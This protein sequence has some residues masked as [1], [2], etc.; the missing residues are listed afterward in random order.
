MSTQEVFFSKK[1]SQL[2]LCVLN[3]TCYALDVSPLKYRCCQ[4]DS[5]IKQ[6]GLYEL[7]D[8]EGSTLVNGMKILMVVASCSARLFCP[9]IFP[10]MR[11]QCS[12]PSEDSALTWQV[13]LLAP[14]C[15][16]SH[17][18]E[19]WE[20]KSVIYKLPALR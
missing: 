6:W 19:L 17:S 20:N 9:S 15:W 11:P 16:T 3:Y 5:I 4:Y 10:H 8:H 1:N 2:Y 12:S 14:W 13:N 18:T 7:L